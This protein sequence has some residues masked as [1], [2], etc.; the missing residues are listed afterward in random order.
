MF[1]IKHGGVHSSY[2]RAQ[3]GSVLIKPKG[4]VRTIAGYLVLS[5]EQAESLVKELHHWLERERMHHG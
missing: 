5:P 3:E 2:V 1:D 4:P